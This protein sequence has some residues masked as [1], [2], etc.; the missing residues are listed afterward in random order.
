MLF[1][2]KH[3]LIFILPI[4]YG[5]Y[6]IAYQD[7]SVF[8]YMYTFSLLI[9]MSASILFSDIYDE[10]PTW[11][12]LAYGSAA[13]ISIYLVLVGM[14]YLFQALD[15][16]ATSTIDRYFSA[17]TPS[18]LW[19]F[20]LLMLIIVPGEELFWRGFVQ[21]QLKQYMPV[22]LAITTASVLFGASMW[23]AD[24]WPGI[25]AS[26]SSGLILGYLYEKKKSMPLLIITHLLVI[27]L[28][29]VLPPFY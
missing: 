21:Q 6:N 3:K 10:L 18:E 13:A 25:V 23:L 5:L 19:H 20:L 29:F 14:Y 1:L 11:K 27:V 15:L 2:K 22:P 24:F 28:L 4:A 7:P 26:I 9:L 17:Y 8:W 12:S 16:V